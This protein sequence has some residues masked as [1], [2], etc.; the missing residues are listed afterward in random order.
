MIQESRIS[1]NLRPY[2]QN[3]CQQL[4]IQ[5]ILF[6]LSDEKLM[7]DALSRLLTLLTTK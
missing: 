6:A 3:L 7:Q 4:K 1:D 2:L 5:K